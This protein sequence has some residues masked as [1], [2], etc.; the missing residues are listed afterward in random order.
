MNPNPSHQEKST[1]YKGLYKPNGTYVSVYAVVT[2]NGYGGAQ[3]S[4]FH[5][6]SRTKPSYWAKINELTE[7]VSP[8]DT[9]PGIDTNGF[10]EYSFAAASSGKGKLETRVGR[11]LKA[12]Y[13]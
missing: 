7:L 1:I 9:N 2:P 11:T 10:R 8:D 5:Q 6:E 3:V 4:L 12:F 13:K